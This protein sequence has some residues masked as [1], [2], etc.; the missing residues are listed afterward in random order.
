LL[1]TSPDVDTHMKHLEMLFDRIQTADL[2]INLEKSQFMKEK[3]KF[4]GHIVTPEAIFVDSEKLEAINEYPVTRNMKKLQTFLGICGFV[5]RFVP[6]FSS[7]AAP[8]DELLR[9]GVKWQCTKEEQPFQQMKQLFLKYTQLD[10]TLEKNFFSY[11][12]ILN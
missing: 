8:L 4:L 5:R 10:H 3:V 12:Q 6:N 1:V 11:K 2:T 7:I 9:D